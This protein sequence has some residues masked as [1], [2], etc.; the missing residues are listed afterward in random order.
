MENP[1]PK[2]DFSTL[3]RMPYQTLQR[4]SQ[5]TTRKTYELDGRYER[6]Y[7]RTGKGIRCITGKQF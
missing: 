6:L 3:V 2:R 7:N 5:K 1:K 4:I